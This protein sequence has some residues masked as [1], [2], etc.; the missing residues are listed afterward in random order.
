M[1]RVRFNHY[2]L[3]EHQVTS[4][5]LYLNRRQLITSA[6]VLTAAAMLPNSGHAAT[7]SRL[8][9]IKDDSAL[10]VTPEAKATT[11]NNFYEFGT[12]KDDPADNAQDFKTTPWSIKVSGHAENTGTF[13][14]EDILKWNPLEERVYRLRCVEAWSMVIPWIGF[15][16]AEMIKRFSPTSDA[17]YVAFQT[18]HDPKQMPGQRNRLMGGGINYPY[19]EGLT[20]EEAMNPL[21]LIAVGMYGKTIP[22]QN[23]APVRLVLPWKYGFKSIKSIVSI[24]FTSEQPETTWN[25]LAPSEYGFYANVNPEVA[26]PRWSQ[27]SERIIG[28]GGIFG[29]KRRDTEIYNGYADQVAHMYTQLGKKQFY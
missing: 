27:A 12:G 4:E 19:V 1:K 25:Q 16:L 18:L 24:R 6:S 8:K 2:S 5:S 10:A 7:Q 3:P 26:H 9:F 29:Q 17:K 20:I 21:T 14:L 28:T 13:H 23:G 15:P 22:P 11:Y